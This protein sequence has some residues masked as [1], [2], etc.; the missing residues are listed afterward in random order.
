MA[1]YDN[2]ASFQIQNDKGKLYVT[3]R[4]KVVN[5]NAEM[6]DGTHKT[7][8][9]KQGTVDNVDYG[10]SQ[11]GKT[12]NITGVSATMDENSQIKLGNITIKSSDNGNGI[13]IGI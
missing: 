7:D 4:G 13:L 12:L 1:L 8:F 6:L 5:L 2:G 11:N 3:D 9:L 10:I